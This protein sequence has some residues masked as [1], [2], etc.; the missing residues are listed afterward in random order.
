MRR[1][2]G[3]ALIEAL[4]VVVVMAII[5]N[6]AVPSY[7]RAR[8]RADAVHVLRDFEAVRIAAFNYFSTSGVFPETSQ[9][10]VPP[11]ELKPLLPEGVTFS[12]K[13]ATYRWERWAL[14]DGLPGDPTTTFLVGLEIESDDA[15]FMRAIR[16][17]YQGPQTLA[18]ANQVTFI[19]Q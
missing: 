4:T 16:D 2:P 6:I 3:F 18:T 11:A 9:E 8:L 17:Q 14:P 13:S 5:A 10:G 12:Y 1:R 19:M 15:A 7:R